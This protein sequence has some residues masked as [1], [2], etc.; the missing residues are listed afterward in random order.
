MQIG[1]LASLMSQPQSV[2]FDNLP[3][4]TISNPKGENVSVVMLRSGK[5]LPQQPAPQQMSRLAD[6]KSEPEADLPVQQQARP[7]PLPFPTRIALARKFETEEDS[8]KMIKMVP[9][10]AKFLKE[11][12]IHKRKKIKGG[13]ETGGV[14]S[15]LVQNE[16]AT[17]GP[18]SVLPKKC[19]DLGIFLVP[20]TISKCTFVDAML[21]LGASINVMPAS[22]YK[23]L[24][25]GDLEPMGMMI[26]LANKS[27]VQPLGILEDDLV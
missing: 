17:T 13:A 18:Q 15:V 27:V 4:Q 1:Q 8:L 25:F 24:N 3:S 10:Y 12:C 16:G 7:V 26:Q 21:D 2:G 19:G 5:E 14:V 6:A 20:C 22:I 23:F 9:K 11:L